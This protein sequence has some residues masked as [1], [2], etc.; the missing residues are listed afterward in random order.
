MPFVSV[1]FASLARRAVRKFRRMVRPGPPAPSPAACW[2]DFA[3][4]KAAKLARVRPLLRPDLPA[5]ETPLFFDFLTAELRRQFAVA[6]T[7]NVSC[8]PYDNVA[9]D[10]IAAHRGGLILD[11]GAGLR[12]AYH[13]NVVNF[14]IAPYD[15]T[16]VRGVGERLPF[17]DG[18]FDAAFSLSVLEHVTDPFACARELARVLKPGGVLYCVVPLLQ[19]YHGY[20]HHYYNMTHTGV[21]NLFAGRLVVEHQGVNGGG[22]PINS[23]TWVLRRWADELP[24]AARREFLDLRVGDLTGEPGTYADRRFVTELPE[25][26]NFELAAATTLIARKPGK[27]S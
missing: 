27:H 19:P 12:P 26:V 21:A 4:R 14:E 18:V 3:A 16:D 10:L 8:H 2:P 11:C 17:R 23:L 24:P 13:E 7:E 20:P 1:P 5:V 25:A 6:D 22:R 9:T 15:T